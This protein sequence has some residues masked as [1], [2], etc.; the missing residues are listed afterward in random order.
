MRAF[1]MR[2]RKQL[3][4]L[5]DLGRKRCSYSK[6]GQF[7]NGSADPASAAAAAGN[8]KTLPAVGADVQVVRPQ[9]AVVSP[10]GDA[11]LVGR[12]GDA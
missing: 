11:E 5:D 9:G 10:G 12:D 2:H 4:H 1:E 8:A 7:E 3:G 6:I